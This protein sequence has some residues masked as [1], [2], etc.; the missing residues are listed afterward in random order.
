MFYL[1]FCS[2][3]S[4]LEIWLVPLQLIFMSVDFFQ[5]KKDRLTLIFNCYLKLISYVVELIQL[6]IVSQFN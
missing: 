2:I 4:I 6:V 3:L 1:H 5:E